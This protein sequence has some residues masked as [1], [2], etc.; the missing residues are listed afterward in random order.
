MSVVSTLRQLRHGPL[1]RFS[2]AWTALGDLYR[3][4]GAARPAEHRIGGYGPFLMQGQFAFSDFE[5]WGGAHNRGFERCIEAC[6]GKSCV[7]DVGAHIGLVTLPMSRAVGDRGRVYAFEPAAANL[8]SLRDHLELNSIDN[9][10]V[11]DALVGATAQQAVTFFEQ[12]RAAG[13]NAVVIKK[14]PEM[15]HQTQR[16]QTTLDGYCET[17]GLAPEVIKIDV[18]GGE[19]GVLQG[20]RQVLAG[21]RPLIILSVHPTELGLRGHGPEEL[22]GLIEETG[23]DCRDIDGNPVDAFRLDEYVLEPVS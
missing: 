11:I 23:Y 9:V 5:H 17:H 3:N 1:R 14:N 22:A 8:A 18:E 21:H 2:P 13:Q 6:R 19:I 7:L 15:Y 10:T 4:F 16:A 20:A 12:S